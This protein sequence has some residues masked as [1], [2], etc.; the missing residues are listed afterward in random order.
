MAQVK[1]RVWRNNEQYSDP[2]AGAAISEVSHSVTSDEV[3]EA[4][5]RFRDMLNTIWHMC[6]LAGF[7]V[8]E[9]IV[10]KDLKT[11]KVWR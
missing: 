11:G 1:T 2:T 4:E 5:L 3:A 6:A 8:E 10:L 9:R 7:H